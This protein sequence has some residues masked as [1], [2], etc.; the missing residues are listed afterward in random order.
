[1]EYK[2]LIKSFFALIAMPIVLVLYP[3]R[4]FIYGAKLFMRSLYSQWKRFEFKKAP[5]NIIISYPIDLHG[6]KNIICG[7][8]VFMGPNGDLSTW[9]SFCGVKYSPIIEIGNN[10]TL[11]ANFHISAINHIKIGN[12]VL[13]GNDITLVDNGHGI[14]N[15]ENMKI[16]PKKR[17]LE[18]Y[19]PLIIE[20][21]VWIG[22]KVTVVGGLTIGTGAIIGSNSVVTK[23]IPPYCVAAG[24][25]ARIIKDLYNITNESKSD[26]NVSSPVSSCSIER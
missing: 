19:D 23:S 21:S 3:F 6:G 24:V 13:T 5:L 17:I 1:M 14:V 15:F 9:S 8:K 7:Q 4:F 22:D 12:N 2:Y 26:S 16:D 11:G 25:P 20:N 10:V 18:M